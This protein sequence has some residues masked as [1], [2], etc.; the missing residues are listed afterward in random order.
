MIP[1]FNDEMEA[2]WEAL[3]GHQTPF[4]GGD[5]NPLQDSCLGNP[6]NRGAWWATVHGVAKSCM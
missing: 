5:G 2:H 1:L 4:G 6:M 3:A